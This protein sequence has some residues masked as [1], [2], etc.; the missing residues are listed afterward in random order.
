MQLTSHSSEKKWFMLDEMFQQNASK[1]AIFLEY[2][3]PRSFF[4][5]VLLH[6]FSPMSTHRAG[7]LFGENE[8]HKKNYKGLQYIGEYYI[9]RYKALK[10]CHF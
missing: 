5:I 10:P 4:Q 7:N 2:E 1:F 6:F 8:K 3:N 9:P